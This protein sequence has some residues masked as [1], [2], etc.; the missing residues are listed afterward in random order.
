VEVS[1]VI[2]LYPRNIARNPVAR[3]IAKKELREVMLETK[4]KLFYKDD[5]DDVR[6]EVLG[7]SDGVFVIAQCY[8]D[9]KWQDTPEFRKLRSAMAVLT[10][11]SEKQFKWDKSWTITVNN[12]IDIC[13][14]KWTKIPS[15]VFQESMKKVLG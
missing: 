13:V 5:G 6:D 4:I 3:A 10:E 15:V 12:A 7:I 11:C 2:R 14:D 1:R 8:V 9:M